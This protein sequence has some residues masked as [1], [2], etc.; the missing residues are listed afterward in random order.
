MK[1]GLISLKS[2]TLYINLCLLET[3]FL[4]N[5]VSENQDF[6]FFTEHYEGFE[7]SKK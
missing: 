7:N 5:I 3:S 4:P 6:G 2:I 1:F